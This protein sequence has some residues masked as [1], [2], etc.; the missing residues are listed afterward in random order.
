M[1]DT[2]RIRS[3]LW[4][5]DVVPDESAGDIEDIL[6]SCLSEIDCLR[7]MQVKLISFIEER[8]PALPE[9]DRIIAGRLVAKA[10]KGL[11]P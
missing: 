8:A 5:D 3:W 4:D 10:K 2:H 9:Y 11:P 6:S 7:E 1:I